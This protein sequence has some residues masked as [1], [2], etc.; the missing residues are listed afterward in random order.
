MKKVRKRYEGQKLTIILDNLQSHKT[1]N[2]K[3]WL[4]EQNDEVEFVFTPKDASCLNQIEIW[5][6]EL[7]QKCLKR[8]SVESVEE[9]KKK[10]NNSFLRSLITTYGL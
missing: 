1:S 5:F 4:K 6:K 7:N 8:L 10:I 3:E 9:L 2:L